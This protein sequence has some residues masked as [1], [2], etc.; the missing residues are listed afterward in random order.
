[1]AAD[2]AVEP[3]GAPADASADRQPADAQ[4]MGA[5]DTSA[6]AFQ[7]CPTG[8]ACRILP[9]GD[10]LTV[11]VGSAGAGGGYRVPLFRRALAAGRAIT[12]VGS[13]ANGPET[14][15]G[16]AFPRGHEGY[17][18]YAID[19]GGGREGLAPIVPRVV[20]AA[21]PHVVLLLAG[22]NDVGATVIDPAHAPERL[23][24]LIDLV[25]AAAPGALIVVAQIPPSMT[26]ATNARIQSFNAALPSIVAGRA[27]VLLVDAYAALAS[28][29]GYKR[30]LMFNEFHPNDAGYARIADRWYEALGPFLH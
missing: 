15:D 25:A 22:T 16:M 17:R 3:R 26:D 30:T 5:E 8:E 12:F 21:R 23:G 20:T 2:A 4:P 7:P 14:V 9:L 13:Q 1:M 28:D 18:G 19:A 29:A 11:G 10:S 24:K 6:A 27:H